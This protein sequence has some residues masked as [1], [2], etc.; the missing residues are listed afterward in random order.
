[1]KALFAAWSNA[2][3]RSGNREQVDL[4]QIGQAIVNQID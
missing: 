2:L 3:N 1:V 4:Q